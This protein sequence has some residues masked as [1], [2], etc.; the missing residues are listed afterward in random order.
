MGYS[1]FIS[2]SSINLFVDREANAVMKG[3]VATDTIAESDALLPGL[4]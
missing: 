1:D 3:V 4:I 2:P